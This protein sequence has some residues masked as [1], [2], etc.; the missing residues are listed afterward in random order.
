MFWGAENMRLYAADLETHKLLWTSDQLYGQSLRDYYPVLAGDVLII[1][2]A[3]ADSMPRHIGRDYNLLTQNAGI[4]ASDWRNVD[5][6]V[7]SDEARGSPELLAQEQDAILQHLE[8][9]PQTRTFYVL[10]RATGQER[11][12][13][14][15]LWC[16]GCQG[17]GQQ[18]VISAGGQAIVMYRT[19]YS[20]WALGVAPLVA[21]GSLSLETGCIERFWHESGNQPP[22]NTFWGTADESQG[23]ALGGHILYITHQGTLSGYDL[24]TKQLFPI[25]GNRDTWGGFPSLGWAHNEWHGPARGSVA[26]AGNMLY[27]LTGSRIIAVRGGGQ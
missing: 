1:R 7:K 16:A 23:F 24:R 8:E 18:P 14:P 3:P 25:A 20:N 9:T 6:F 12:R 22:W 4:D 5:A 10:D 15:V 2:S 13:A 17:V 19:A 27:W 21:M 11:L 26:I